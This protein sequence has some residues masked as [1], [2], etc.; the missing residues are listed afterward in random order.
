MC[1]TSKTEPPARTT[2]QALVPRIRSLL[3]DG[4]IR[5][6][7]SVAVIKHHHITP[8]IITIHHDPKL[9]YSKNLSINNNPIQQIQ[10]YLHTIKLNYKFIIHE[11]DLN[12]IFS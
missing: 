2:V 8:L 9:Q 1:E 10:Q 5:H 3:D 4:D 12:K 7:A 6:A 11:H